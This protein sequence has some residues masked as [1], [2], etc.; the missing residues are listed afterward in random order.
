[1]GDAFRIGSAELRAVRGRHEDLS[2]NL[3]LLAVDLDLLGQ[4][5]P[6]SAALLREQVQALAARARELSSSVHQLGDGTP[7]QGAPAPV[8]RNG[9][10][11]PRQREVLRLLARGHS[12]K[13]AA[14]ILKITPRTVAFHKYSMMEELGIRTSAELIRYAI[15]QHIV[16]C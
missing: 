6:E 8:A 1:M 12:M 9:E 4:N 16:T 10:L 7:A 13:E 15:Q 3:A 14:R 11:S 2:R 5:P